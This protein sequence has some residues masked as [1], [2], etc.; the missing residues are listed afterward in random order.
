MLDLF[1]FANT[2]EGREQRTVVANAYNLC[3]REV[4]E[5]EETWTDGDQ[6]TT[7]LR[8]EVGRRVDEGRIA[9]AMKIA[10]GRK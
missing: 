7:V 10:K 3:G 9:T 1:T 6:T 5:F 8:L 2:N 4:R